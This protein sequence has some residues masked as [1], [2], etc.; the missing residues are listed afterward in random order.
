MDVQ[1]PEMDGLEATRIIRDP[2]SPVLNH[3]VPIIA[4]TAHAITGDRNRCLESGMNDYVSKPVSPQA[5]AEALNAW[6]PQETSERRPSVSAGEASVCQ[7]VP[8]VPVFDRAG[9]VDRMMGD[10]AFADRILTRFLESTPP[11]IESLRESLD[12]GDAATA[13]RIAH[14]IKGAASNIGGER[15]H[16]VAFEI[17][18]AA[19]NADLPRAIRHFA[20]LQSQFEQL[21]EIIQAKE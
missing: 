2:Q 13:K 17:E 7:S 5:L 15:L 8:E 12:S 9:L 14:T 21:K 10:V 20:E 11:Q 19:R 4:M 16:T 1:M 6:L 3:Q 18:E